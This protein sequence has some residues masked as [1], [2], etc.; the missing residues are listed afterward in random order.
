MKK[1][2]PTAGCHEN[3]AT[4]QMISLLT[5]RFTKLSTNPMNQGDWNNQM[6]ANRALRSGTSFSQG[7]GQGAL[8]DSPLN[9]Y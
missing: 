6:S 1:I 5:K 2:N 4:H 9:F 7:E 3:C 8:M